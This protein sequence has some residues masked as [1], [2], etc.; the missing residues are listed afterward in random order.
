MT[1]DRVVQPPTPNLNGNP[2]TFVGP[3]LDGNFQRC[4]WRTTQPST[5]GLPSV[6][7]A[8]EA[9]VTERHRTAARGDVIE[10]LGRAVPVQRG[11]C[12]GRDD[13]F[14]EALHAARMTRGVHQLAYGRAVLGDEGFDLG[15][16]L[17]KSQLSLKGSVTGKIAEARHAL[18]ELDGGL[19]SDDAGALVRLMGLDRFVSADRTH[20][21]ISVTLEIYTRGDGESHRDGLGRVADELFG[22]RGD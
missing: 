14:R 1:R 2:T 21:R 22:D 8:I 9:L 7:L 5:R 18:L 12:A 20:A 4:T 10:L 11:R 17:G 19:T 16:T 3:S 15:G 13:G 6:L